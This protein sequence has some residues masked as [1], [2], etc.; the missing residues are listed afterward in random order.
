[1]SLPDRVELLERSLRKERN[2]RKIRDEE[3]EQMA[4]YLEVVMNFL[5]GTKVW[6]GRESFTFRKA[7]I[8]RPV[9]ENEEDA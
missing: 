2:K 5:D 7:T 3:I 4:D 9:V 1:M 6:K 8:S